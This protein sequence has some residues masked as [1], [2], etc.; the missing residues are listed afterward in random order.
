MPPTP[1][2]TYL[3][4]NR[5]AL[6]TLV[7]VLSLAAFLAYLAYTQAVLQ[8]SYRFRFPYLDMEMVTEALDANPSP[9]LLDLY[10]ML[11]SNE[12]R[13]VLAYYW[14]LWDRNYFGASGE[15]L[16]RAIYAFNGLLVLTFLWP[17]L[18]LRR[19]LGIAPTALFVTAVTYWFFAAFNW[20]NLTFSIQVCE[21]SCLAYMS[22]GLL[23]STFIGGES[24]PTRDA[25][26]AT[27][28]GA[29]CL[30][31]SYSFGMG[32]VSWPVI[33]IHAVLTRW[34][35]TPLLI[36]GA[37]AAFT[38]GTYAYWYVA[39]ANFASDPWHTSVSSA[40]GHPI[41]LV[42][43]VLNVLAWPPSLTFEGVLSQRFGRLLML[44]ASLGGIA[45]AAIQ[46][47]LL[48]L[49]RSG[50]V[51]WRQV[52]PASFHAAMLVIAALGI[53]ALAGVTRSG[54]LSGFGR[55]SYGVVA[56]M[57]WCGLVALFV[58]ELHTAAARR[59]LIV[60]AIFTAV[61]G[62]VPSRLF[63]HE[64]AARDQELYQAGVL[65]T[66]NINFYPD[67]PYLAGQ[68]PEFFE[69]WHR[70]RSP[71]P[72]YAER[73]PFKWLGHSV[74]DLLQSSAA[75]CLGE[76]EGVS[77]TEHDPG[78]LSVTGWAVVTAKSATL[79]WVLVADDNNI[80]VGAGKPGLPS[81]DVPGQ[82]KAAD[83]NALPEGIHDARFNAFAVADPGRH[84]ALWA[85]D[86]EGRPCRIGPVMPDATKAQ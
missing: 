21:I 78:V 23:L 8:W 45:L 31:A 17:A 19:K 50:F 36:F 68:S 43:F 61:M 44:A 74:P 51:A 6:V 56:S 86:S 35:L 84:L 22:L 65:A 72:S 29:L 12:H 2:Q 69:M 32:L 66:L 14:Y 39:I 20:E 1:L 4:K 24:S 28:A 80:V 42:V 64:I 27:L 3:T 15:L 85:I 53:A 55:S 47:T 77:P 33:A 40:L 57:F 52:R 75:S 83:L 38:L 30:V 71:A 5:L 37:F 25:L 9:R 34:R 46:I 63:Q 48:Y 49:A 11:N 10:R 62:Y 13:I 16:Y 73:E 41:R 26:L 67:Q 7:F 60:F 76:V 82:L 58:L 59:C 81:P 79:R 54:V 70:S 18:Y